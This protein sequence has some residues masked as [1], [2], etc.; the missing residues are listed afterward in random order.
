MG[1]QNLVD[2]GIEEGRC[3]LNTLINRLLGE[4]LQRKP[5]PAAE[6]GGCHIEGKRG[7]RAQEFGVWQAALPHTAYF[8]QTT[9]TAIAQPVQNHDHA[10]GRSIGKRGKAVG[11]KCHGGRKV[12]QIVILV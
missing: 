10:I 4:C 3:R 12:L 6:I 8:E 1:R 9:R 11:F 2:I 5:L 7:V